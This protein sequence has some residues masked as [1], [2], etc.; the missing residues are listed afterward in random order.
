MKGALSRAPWTEDFGGCPVSCK[1]ASVS[2]TQGYTLRWVKQTE[3]LARMSKR[4]LIHLP[5]CYY[6]AIFFKGNAV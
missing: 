6:G 4:N 3:S 1:Y 5:G 2:T